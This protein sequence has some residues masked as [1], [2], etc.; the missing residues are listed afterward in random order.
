MTA[1]AVLFEPGRAG[2]AA[3]EEAAER[4]DDE[5]IVVVTAPQATQPRCCGPSPAAFNC[6]VREDSAADLREAERLLGERSA[7]TRF[8]LLVEGRD[9]PLAEWARQAGVD[10]LLLPARRRPLASGRHPELRALR[11]VDGL[12]VRVVDMRARL[13]AHR[14]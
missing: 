12:D 4:A 7:Q 5:L 10:V 9:P 3:L 14:R 11:E 6:A 8:V 1:V 13:A 2:I